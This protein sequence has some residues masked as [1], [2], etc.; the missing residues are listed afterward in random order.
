[1]RKST[2]MQDLGLILIKILVDKMKMS[3]PF[4]LGNIFKNG[5][6]F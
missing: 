3:T 4:N 1:M 6:K 2:F 5:I